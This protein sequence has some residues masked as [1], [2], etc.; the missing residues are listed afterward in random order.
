MNLLSFGAEVHT[1]SRSEVQPE[2]R[3]ALANGRDI[4]K[5]SLF[6]PVNSNADATT[7][8][9]VK[10][11]EPLVDGDAVVVGVTLQYLERGQEGS[12]TLV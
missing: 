8:L 7:D 9:N 5:V 3:Y 2:F 10:R 12:P 11:G 4:T 6:H 1:I